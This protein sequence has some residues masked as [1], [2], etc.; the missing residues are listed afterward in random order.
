MLP[1]AA[2]AFSAGAL[3]FF[4]PCAYPLLPAY[5]SYYVGTSS[6]PESADRPG[7]TA[8]LGR[9]AGVALLVS[10]G[11]FLV[12]AAL[13]GIVATLGPRLLADIAVLELI[14]GGL[15][16]VL[17]VAMLAG[18]H[19]GATIRLPRRRRSV[20]GYVGFGIVYAVAAAG[21]TAPV[22]IAVGLEALSAGPGGAAVTFGAYLAG[23]SALML[24]VTAAAALGRETVLARARSLP[25]DR[26]AGTLLVAAGIVEIYLFLFRFDGFRTLGLA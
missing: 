2:F 17:G 23:M 11:F 26:I 16:I 21:C 3:T 10:V 13:A 1:L 6:R 18:W 12:F 5:V 20:L 15:L 19:P 25:I 24:V 14:V 9:A 22:F 8:A 7:G 4:A